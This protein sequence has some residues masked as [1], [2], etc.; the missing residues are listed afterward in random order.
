MRVRPVAASIGGLVLAVAACAG[1]PTRHPA[2]QGHSP[3]Q[4]QAA[5]GA[6]SSGAG[7]AVSQQPCGSAT[8]STYTHVIWIWMENRSYSSVL[9]PQ[10]GAGRLA[11]YAKKCGVA[12]RYRAIAHPSLPNYIAAVSGS[13]HGISS[14]CDPSACPVDAGSVYG[15]VTKAGRHWGAYAE[16]MSRHCDHRSYGRYAARHNPA[17][18]FPPLARQC[19]RRDGALGGADGRFARALANQQLPA[20]SFVTPNLCNDGH[21]CSTDVADRWL[22]LWLDRI[23]ASPSYGSG[24]TVVIVTWDEGAY[25][26]DN[27]VAAVV[28]APTVQPGTRVAT[29]FTHYSLLRTTEELL[30]L[31]KLRN[32]KSATSMRAGFGL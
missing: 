16:S 4:H 28:I 32:A 22:K 25:G 14:D 29:A 26:G 3:V 23:T 12:T 7:V 31:P 8:K 27:R 17:V 24:H 19:L 5:R 30:G 10:G 21:D 1:A 2:T 15:Q 20:F 9:G 13:T 6:S 11:A 18:Y